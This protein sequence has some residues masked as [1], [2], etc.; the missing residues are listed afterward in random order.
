MSPFHSALRPFASAAIFYYATLWLIVLVVIGTV[1]QKFFG[2][3]DSLH[4]YFSAWF[5]Q[6]MDMPIYLPS[7]RFVM[8]VIMLNLCAKL[9]VGTQWKAKMIG[10]N[11]THLGV[12]ILMIGGSITAFT[13]TEG[14]LAVREGEESSTVRDFHKVELAVTDTSHA[15]YDEVTTFTE[16]F[17]HDQQSFSDSKTPL[18]FKVLKFYKNCDRAIR[19][20]SEQSAQLR[21]IASQFALRELASDKKDANIPGLMVEVSGASAGDNGVYLFANHPAWKPAPISGS[22]GKTYL[23]ALRSREYALPFSIHLKDFEKLDHAGTMMARAFSSKVTV[24]EKSSSEDV[25]IYMNHP[26][27]RGGYTL[28]QAS[29]NQNPADGMETSYLQVVHNKGRHLPYIA[30]VVITLG[31]LIH[32]V[33]QIPRLLVATQQKSAKR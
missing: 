25:K 4:V 23:V 1:A 3:Y 28:Y 13:T 22:D 10:I 6:P 8:T 26:L 11:I 24:K 15:D 17:F 9:L 32:V 7:G 2:L 16:G 31:L 20:A 19:P 33:L 12:M 27:R 18:S 14:S 5:I 29:F 21:G 30:I